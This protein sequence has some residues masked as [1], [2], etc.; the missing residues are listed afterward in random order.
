MTFISYCGRLAAC[1]AATLLMIGCT[2]PGGGVPGDAT[3]TGAAGDNV[4]NTPGNWNTKAVP[5]ETAAIVAPTGT[6]IRFTKDWSL[7]A[8]DN[9]GDD[10]VTVPEG[11]SVTASGRGLTVCC[12]L[13]GQ[14]FINGT[15]IGNVSFGDTTGATV[16]VIGG[17][18]TIAGSITQSN[19]TLSP[20]V[21]EFVP[22]TLTLTVKGNYLLSRTGA[23]AF[24]LYADRP[25]PKLELL[26]SA[27]LSGGVL[28]VSPIHDRK[29]PIT[30]TA[31]TAAQGIKGD[32]ASAQIDDPNYTVSYVF[33]PK[34]NPT[35]LVVTV[36]PKRR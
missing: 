18:G 5:T 16:R 15:L 17:N 35:D 28:L 31:M 27:T 1:L 11:V 8:I 36:T 32:F 34:V 14:A 7:K 4:F 23:L 25:T 29:T 2:Q 24:Y 22:E 6:H 26:G 21:G 13:F 10:A 33:Q 12:S 30:F 3:W 9:G 20:G 19:S